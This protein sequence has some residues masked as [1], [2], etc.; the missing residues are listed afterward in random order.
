MFSVFRPS[1][2]GFAYYSAPSP[3]NAIIAPF[4]LPFDPAI[5]TGIPGTSFDLLS[6]YVGGEYGIP[7]TVT[8]VSCADPDGLCNLLEMFYV[9][10]GAKEDGQAFV[11]ADLNGKTGFGQV[12]RIELTAYDENF[13]SIGVTVDNIEVIVYKDGEPL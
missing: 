6:I 2:Y 10:V 11:K 13:Q 9:N 3:D 1:D 12:G 4:A 7:C 8:I 5:I